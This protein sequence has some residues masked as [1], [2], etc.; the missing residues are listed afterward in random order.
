[1]AYSKGESLPSA[2]GSEITI[3]HDC[4]RPSTLRFLLPKKNAKLLNVRERDEV[5]KKLTSKPA[6]VGNKNGSGLA[7]R[8]VCGKKPKRIDF[9]RPTGVR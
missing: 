3:L 5:G 8:K 9:L 6:R 4:N 7:T 1:V 2:A